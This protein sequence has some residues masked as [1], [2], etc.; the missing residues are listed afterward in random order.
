MKKSIKEQVFDVLQENLLASYPEYTGKDIVLCPICL[1]EITKE[2][3]IT[4]GMERIIPLS[5]IKQDSDRQ[6]E[7]A[8]KNQRA[9]ITIL[10]RTSRKLLST[11]EVCK[12]GCNGLKGSLYDLHLKKMYRQQPLSSTDYSQI[13]QI[14]LLIIAYLFAFQRYGYG[15]IL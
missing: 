9:G 15:Y 11:D 12:D 10:C 5:A 6:K 1:S 4:K 7:L 3:V 14:S 8:Y 13:H 2:E